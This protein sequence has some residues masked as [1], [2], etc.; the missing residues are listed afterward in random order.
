[1]NIK[2]ILI[3][4]AILVFAVFVVQNSQAVM[5]SFLFWKIEAS[6]AIVLM[7]TF[8]FGLITGLVSA[9]VFKK[10]GQLNRS[11]EDKHDR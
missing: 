2:R 7:V 4:A 1:M 5:V 11:V 8:V 3:V 10:K 6:R 9:Q